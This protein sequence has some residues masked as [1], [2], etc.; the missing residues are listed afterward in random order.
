MNPA[1]VNNAMREMMAQLA[2][3]YAAHAWRTVGADVPSDSLNALTESGIYNYASTDTGVPSAATGVV[4]HLQRTTDRAIQI[5]GVATSSSQLSLFWRE[6][7]GAGWS[8]WRDIMHGEAGSSDAIQFYAD[9][10][11][12][13]STESDG[14]DVDAAEYGV[15]IGATGTLVIARSGDVPVRIKRSND[16]VL[17]SWYTGT[18]LIGTVSASG[19][20][21]SY[22]SFC[23]S[24]WSQ[25]RGG[26]K[27]EILPGTILE[28]IDHLCVWRDATEA[29]LP[30]VQVATPGSRAVYGVFSHLD[31]DGDMHVAALGA[32]SIRM[33]PGPVPKRGDLIEAGPRGCG[34]VQADD[35]FRSS[36]VA[37]V[38]AGVQ[39]SRYADGSF[40]VPCTLHCG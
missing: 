12:V 28:S 5:A 3:D 39:T 33:A 26:V 25:L 35:V 22:G 10:L 40:L 16:G 29:V 1:G 9:N 19:G 23:G 14:I 21:V 32:N 11:T 18:S 20:V 27:R 6:L 17:V 24:H 30:R 4:L 7:S 15:A 36:T 34:V 37:K 13:S 31:E 2:T 38:T 8:A